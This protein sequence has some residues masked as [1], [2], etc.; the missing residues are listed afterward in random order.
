LEKVCDAIPYYDMITIQGG[1]KTK[2]WKESYLCPACGGHSL[3]NERNNNEKRIV[4][5]ALGRDLGVRGTCYQHKDMQSANWISPGDKIS[6]HI[7]HFR[8]DRKHCT[9]VLMWEVWEVPE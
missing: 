8:I 5:F 4:N 3:H 6:N 9:N 1:F 2:I 7:D